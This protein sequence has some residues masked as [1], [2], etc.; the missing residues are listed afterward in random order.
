GLEAFQKFFQHMPADSGMAF[1]LVQHLDP[2]HASS[3]PELLSRSTKM[4]VQQATDGMPVK[5]NQVYIIPPNATLTLDDGSLRV[6]TPQHDLGRRTP[7]DTFF[8]SLAESQGDNAVCIIL[9]G[10]GTD[11]TLGLRAIKEYGG[12][13]IAQAPESAKYAGMP[14]SA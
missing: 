13:A 10:S 3:M 9:S 5:P 1:V 4:P 12:L 6:V 7:I 2:R 11:G 8:S 14:S